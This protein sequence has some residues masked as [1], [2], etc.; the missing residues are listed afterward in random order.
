MRDPQESLCFPLFPFY[1]ATAEYRHIRAEAAPYMPQSPE[2]DNSLIF[3]SRQSVLCLLFR[4]IGN[5][6]INYI[7]KKLIIY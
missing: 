4:R 3:H 7:W 5:C 2:F 1:V 6:T